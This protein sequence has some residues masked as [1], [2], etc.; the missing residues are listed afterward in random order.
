[1]QL[2]GGQIVANMLADAG[3]PYAVG[4]PGHGCLQLVD[5]LSQVSDRLKVLQPLHES[6]AVHLADGYYRASGTPLAV[7]TSIGPGALNT[8]I[9]LAT[10]YVD[11]TAVLA[12]TG[13]V[14]VHMAGVGVLQE[15][16]RRSDAANWRPLESVCKRHFMAHQAGQ[17]P[18]MVSR[19][20]STMLQGRPGPA[21]IGLPMDVQAATVDVDLP[22]VAVSLK[23]LPAPVP[24]PDAVQDAAKLLRS[25]QRPVILVGGGVVSARATHELRR[26]AEASGA[27]VVN[28]MM[29]QGAF[30]AD[31]PLYGWAT[32]SKGT[33]CGMALTQSA[34]VILAVGARFADETASSYRHGAA[35]NMP[36]TRL[37][38]LDLDPHEIGK[39]YPV[40]V[41]LVG[42]ARAGLAALAAALEDG[43]AVD[44]RN[45]DYC[46]G[47]QRL[48]AE[49]FAFLAAQNDE[50]LE[51]MTISSLL[52]QVRAALSRD[53]FVVYSSGNTQ[54]QMIQE[55]PF[56]EPGTSLTTGGFS[57][58]GFTLPAALGAK[59]AHP[60]RPVVGIIGDGDFLMHV[61]ELSTAVRYGIPVVY[62]VANNQGWISIRDLQMAAFGEDHAFA[63]D[64]TRAGSDR[65]HAG[66]VYSPDL[67]GIARDFGCWST[68]ISRADQ[69]ARA[70]AE[71]FAADRPAVIEA[72]VNREWPHTGT[73]AVGWWD[74]PIPG[75]L[76]GRTQY[77]EGRGEE[78]I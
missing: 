61:Q 57:T 33:S 1:M 65:A 32:G 34:D 20:F 31:H 27:A 26:V 40:E 16:E 25:A 44:W 37:I 58:M 77:E 56:Y 76:P 39:N 3:V 62:I 46:A 22:A 2:T 59:L 9:G 54:A 63:T 7:F 73:P 23:P 11:S 45:S 72:T 8:A 51:P 15:M 13:E 70:I 49:W 19:A 18:R 35:F 5:A 12:L 28:T 24:D 78:R 74:V 4:I 43:P 48:R 17:L 68:R 14:H 66:D 41:A 36:P 67:A 52:R 50:A 21:V 42:D 30:P 60:G 47:I 71:A 6:A 29:G 10:A 75:Y 55:F 53:T 38:H 64:F 69:V